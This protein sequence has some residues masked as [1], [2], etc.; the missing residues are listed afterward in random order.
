MK[1]EKINH[2]LF[3]NKADCCGCSACYSAC[4]IKAISMVE[5]EEG[6]LY[7]HINNS[8]CIDCG[9]C[10]KMCPNINK[11]ECGKTSSFYAVKHKQ[12]DIRS[13]S[14]SGGIFSAMAQTI[15]S[16]GG[17]VYGA[18]YDKMFS[19]RHL[20]TTDEDWTRLRTSKY[21]QSDMGD[22]FVDVKEDLLRGNEVLFTGT[23]C[24]I[25]GLKNYL[26]DVDTDKLITSDLV[27]H[28]V[29]SPGIWREY[30]EYISKKTKSTIGKV[31]FRNKNGCG[32]HNSTIKIES[33]NGDVLLDESKSQDF[34]YR[35]FFNH[36]ILRPCCYSCQYANLNRVGDITIGDYW[37][38]ENHYPEFDDDRGVS[39]VMINTD[40]GR[41][42]FDRIATECCVTSIRKEECMQPNLK[43]PA[44][45]YGG[46]DRFWTLYKKYGLEWTGKRIGFLDKTFFDEMIIF[47]MRLFDK[48]TSYIK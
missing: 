2:L 10:I 28:G 15:I 43:K 44:K 36:L 48:I 35:L 6:F 11:N 21:V 31:N 24:Q 32:W 42:F 39:L 38:I 9:L 14:S 5:D 4:P 18:T 41:M 47:A 26:S 46:R 27:C 20:R 23:P 40:K 22:N 17:V 34:F 16:S 13:V 12:E 19:V 33:T 3:E 8:K 30:L 1:S 29:P 37:G 45:D 7:P 25:A